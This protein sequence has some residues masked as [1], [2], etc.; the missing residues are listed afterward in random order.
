M[1]NLKLTLAC[2]DYDRT[3]ALWDGRVSPEGIDLTYIRLTP[4]EI[5]FRMLEHNEFDI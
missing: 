3:R 5:F 1:P 2:G 4:E